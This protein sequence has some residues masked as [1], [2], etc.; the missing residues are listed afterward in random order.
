MSSVLVFGYYVFPVSKKYMII[1]KM[2]R[3]Y[4]EKRLGPR[5]FHFSSPIKR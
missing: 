5:V 2:M 1:Q 3:V 4:T